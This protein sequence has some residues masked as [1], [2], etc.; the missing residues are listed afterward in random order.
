LL[1]CASACGVPPSEERHV[2]IASRAD[3]TE[4]ADFIF[5]QSEQEKSEPIQSFC[6]GKSFLPPFP[7]LHEDLDL[8]H[9][10]R[11][12]K[13]NWFEDNGANV[14]YQRLMANEKMAEF[15]GRGVT[16]LPNLPSVYPSCPSDISAPLDDKGLF[17]KY[18]TVELSLPVRSGDFVF[19]EVAHYCGPLCASGELLALHRN[20]SGKWVVVERRGLWIS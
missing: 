9:L 11:A 19:L 18:R 1:A 5:V 10:Q 4:I 7:D 14:A 15:A 16:A 6:I 20:N 3:Q 8:S 12:S 13:A 17:Y 2:E